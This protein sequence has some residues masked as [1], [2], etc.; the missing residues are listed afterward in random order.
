LNRGMGLQSYKAG[1]RLKAYT[2]IKSR[3]QEKIY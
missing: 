1:L 3:L 2:A